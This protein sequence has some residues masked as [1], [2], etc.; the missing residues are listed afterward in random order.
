MICDQCEKLT[1]DELYER[2]RSKT[3]LADW[4][5]GYLVLYPSF[6]YLDVGAK[7]GCA[8][9]QTFQKSFINLYGSETILKDRIAAISESN[10]SAPPVIT[11]VTMGFPNSG[12]RPISTLHLQV[13]TKVRKPDDNGIMIKFRISK[14]RGS[15][16]VFCSSFWAV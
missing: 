1:I 12:K 8:T 7:N 16:S 2:I 15:F 3:L 5:H 4:S 13:G 10:G 6:R 14:I 9:C 11:F